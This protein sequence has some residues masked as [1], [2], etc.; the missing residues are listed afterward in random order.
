M[1][2]SI[3]F[4]VGQALAEPLRRHQYQAPVS[5]HL[6][7]TVVSGIGNCIWVGFPSWDSL[8]MI[9]PS[10][11]APHFV[12]GSPPNG[13]LIPLLRRTEVSTLWS[14][15]FLGLMWSVNCILGILNFW[16]NVQ[17]S[18]SVYH[19]WFFVCLFV[20][21]FVFVCLYVCLL[22]LGYLTQDDIF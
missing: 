18:V 8:W 3:Y 10:V 9:F 21:L 14:S 1:A 11:S 15:L 2:L 22:W 6:A 4:C 12:S 20:C 7:Y 13:I 19:V 5:K 17:F 16:A